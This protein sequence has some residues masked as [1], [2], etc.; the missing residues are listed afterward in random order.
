[1]SA[2][3]RAERR[4]LNVD[5]MRRW[6][7]V[8]AGVVATLV[9]A[10]GVAVA[11]D[12]LVS[13]VAPPAPTLKS[14]SAA[15]LGRIGIA[16]AGAAQPP[17]CGLA[18]TAIQNRWVRPG[19]AGCAIARDA[20]QAAALHGGAALYQARVVESALARVTM[21]SRPVVGRDHLA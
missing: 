2:V 9:L 18:R 20:A 6:I 11:A 13:P 15:T 17:Y 19:F 8:L 14:A 12:R 5:V 7:P 10:G 4:A 16:L 3:T 21:P 1:M